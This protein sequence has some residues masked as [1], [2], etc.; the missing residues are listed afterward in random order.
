MVTINFNDIKK[1]CVFFVVPRS[2]MLLGMP[3]MAALKIININVDSIQAAKEE[4]NTNI[5][6]TKESNT[7]HK[8]HV[9][10]KSCINMD[11]D[12]KVNN[13]VN[14][15]N[16]Y[17]WYYSL[18]LVLLLIGGTLLLIHL[19]GSG[20]PAQDAWPILGICGLELHSIGSK[21][22]THAM[23]M[24]Y[25]L[26]YITCHSKYLCYYPY[27]ASIVLSW[28]YSLSTPLGNQGCLLFMTLVPKLLLLLSI[29]PWCCWQR[30]TH[31]TRTSFS[32]CICISSIWFLSELQIWVE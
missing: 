11:A 17:Q 5:G 30:N 10:E 20:Y 9:V 8:V 27:V 26:F 13:N 12:S 16:S 15:H 29:S 21:K 24:G 1:R 7:T 18:P 2:Q 3:D 32:L 19:G 22:Y 23:A 4:C 31:Y 25:F 14:G 28:H 6:D